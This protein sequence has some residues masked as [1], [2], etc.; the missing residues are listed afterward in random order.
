MSAP[1]LDA[2]MDLAHMAYQEDSR[3][4]DGRPSRINVQVDHATF[5]SI[6]STERVVE[7]MRGGYLRVDMERGAL[8]VL[9]GILTIK[10]REFT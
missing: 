7:L 2:I 10:P 5:A 8:V 6:R 9:D 3:R 4:H 1:V